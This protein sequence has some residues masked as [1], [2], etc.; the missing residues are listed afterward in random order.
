MAEEI[1]RGLASAKELI[2]GFDAG[3]STCSGLATRIEERVGSKLVIRN[4]RDPEL[5]QWRRE[6]L[7]EAAPWAPTLFEVEGG[8]V[9]AWAG[10][11]M[12]LAL[13]RR[14]GPK[15]TWRVMQIL[16]EIGVAPRLQDTSVLEALPVRTQEAVAGISR[17]QF[18]KGVGGAAVAASLLSGGL[19]LPSSALAQTTSSS[20][21]LEQQ[22]LTRSIV[23]N[24][25][26]FLALKTQQ[27]QV[28]AV[29]PFAQAKITVSGNMALL[30]VPSPSAVDHL[31]GVAASFAVNLSERRLRNYR[32]TVFGR[33]D[34]TRRFKLTTFDNGLPLSRYHTALIAE[35]YVISE[36]AIMSHEEF[37]TRLDT[38]ITGQTATSGTMTQQ[39][40][41]PYIDQRCY[42]NALNCCNNV[43]V[44][45]G[46]GGVGLIVDTATGGIK[47]LAGWVGKVSGLS[48][49]FGCSYFAGRTGGCESMARSQCLVQPEETAVV[50]PRPPSYYC[51]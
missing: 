43:I 19:S 51:G 42:D 13:S 49:G 25:R 22:T 47:T 4:L 17:G 30:S 15:D 2:L 50:Q 9:R 31:T 35:T 23:R 36:N 44:N 6:A 21:T 27:E 18:L 37:R 40:T 41:S 45:A 24:S 39:S 11:K 29:F 32:H 38:Y 1:G 12:G 5:M 8:K 46:C 20:G 33:S 10:M 14:L 3:C 34:A 26:Q 48:S 28:G 7:G 16:G